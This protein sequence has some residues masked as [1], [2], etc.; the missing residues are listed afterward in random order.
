MSESVRTYLASMPHFGMLPDEELDHL[1]K[2]AESQHFAKDHIMAHQGQTRIRHIYIIKNGQISIYDEMS[3]RRELGGYIKT[4]EVFGGITLLMNAGI[5]LRTVL[6][7]TET[8]AYLIPQEKFLDLCARYKEF[9]AFFVDNFSKN[10]TDPALDTIIASG[11]AKIFL[12]GVAPFS[13]LPDEALE[14]AADG[15]SMVSHP[16]DTILFSQGRTRI[17]HLYILQK[18]SAERYYEQDGKKNMRDMLSEGDLYGGISM[19]LND[20]FRSERWK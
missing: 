20:A 17:G 1:A 3:G 12:S 14:K 15:L 16:K 7:D 10:I 5:S 8:D 6:V 2:Q 18:G 19:L 9:Y 13:F 4:G 11:Q